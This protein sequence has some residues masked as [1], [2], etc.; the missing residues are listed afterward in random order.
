MSTPRVE[1]HIVVIDDFIM[2]FINNDLKLE[3]KIN[4]FVKNDLYM[5]KEKSRQIVHI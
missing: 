3:G 2:L 1:W 5:I 4:L